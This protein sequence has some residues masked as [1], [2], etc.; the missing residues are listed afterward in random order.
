MKFYI[1][2][3][4]FVGFLLTVYYFS[5]QLQLVFSNVVNAIGV[6]LGY[7]SKEG[8]LELKKYVF[9]HRSSLVAKLYWFVN[10]LII[11]M[12]MKVSGVTPLGFLLFWAIIALIL[13]VF[14]TM[15]LRLG[16]IGVIPLFFILLV[17]E[18][19][20]IRV[21]ISEKIE[22]REACI[23]DAVDLI[24][25][26]LRNGVKNAI[27]FQKQN[28][29]P[30][31]VDDFNEFDINVNQRKMSFND[32]M[33]ILSDNLGMLFRDFA[34][35]AISFE[36]SGDLDMLDIFVEIVETNRLR[37]ELRDINN[38][39]FS[40]IRRDF[41]VSSVLMVA[42]AFYAM[43]TDKFTRVFLTSTTFGKF[44]VIFMFADTIAVLAFI[45]MIKSK[46]L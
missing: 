40:A 15:I 9:L 13:S 41:I 30:L 44:I 43:A 32:A 14:C 28:F 42:Y 6:K 29:S 24:I 39:R 7:Y 10:D 20:L 31:I 46:S 1:T 18:I 25:P 8:E 33:M 19:V 37:R 21:S 38:V 35:K 12:G 23:M 2:I 36:Q 22:R 5:Y 16:F 11:N 26:E 34:Q 27:L 45:S 4:C 3:A 17:F